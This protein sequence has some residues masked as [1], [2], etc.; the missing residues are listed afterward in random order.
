MNN[1]IV[2][3]KCEDV[4]FIREEQDEEVA[5]VDDLDLLDD[6]DHVLVLQDVFLADAL[7]LELDTEKDI[8]NIIIICL[9]YKFYK[10]LLQGWGTEKAPHLAQPHLSAPS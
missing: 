6:L 10:A 8:I 9:R 4:Q 5:C 2:Y 1:T 3:Y 7:R